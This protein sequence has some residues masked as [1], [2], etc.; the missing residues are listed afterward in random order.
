MPL[1]K[2]LEKTFIRRGERRGFVVL[3]I[4]AVQRYGF[5]DRTVLGPG[6]RIGFAELKQKGEKPEPLQEFWLAILHRFGFVAHVID[7]LDG[8]D[9]FYLAL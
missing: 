5:P 8:V 7:D 6:R 9:Q 4:V 2:N 1:E 3:K